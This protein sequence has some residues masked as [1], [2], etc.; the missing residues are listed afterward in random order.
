MS[1]RWAELRLALATREPGCDASGANVGDMTFTAPQTRVPVLTWHGYNLFGNSYETNDLIA[2]AEDLRTIHETGFVVVP[3]VEVARWACGDRADFSQYDRPVVALSCDDGTD[4]DWKNLVHPEH[5]T[6]QSFVSRMRA[7]QAEHP[8]AQPSLTLTSFVIASPSAR[9]QIDRGGMGAQGALN[10]DW[11]RVANEDGLINIESHGWDH[12]HPTVSPVVQREQRTGD[13]FAID[14][15]A[16][17]DIHIRAASQFIESKSGRKPPL[18]AYPWT[19]ASDYLRREYMPRYAE[20]NGV[21]AAFGGQS[22]YITKN[23]DRWY[24]PRFV[25]GPDWK[26]KEGL[27]KLLRAAL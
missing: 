13:F 9:S 8:G 20:S 12:N 14:T 27:Q 25:Y 17:C 6:Q 4:Y 5:G 24:L 16:E 22:D 3:L 19:Q 15:F 1:I 21:I 10:D 18:F 7:F 11:W 2:F 23:S 26:S